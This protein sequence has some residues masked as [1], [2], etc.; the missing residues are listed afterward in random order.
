MKMNRTISKKMKIKRV[1]YIL[2]IFGMDAIKQTI[3]EYLSGGEKRKLNVASEFL[4]D[5]YFIFCDEPTTGLDS[6]NA[7]SVITSLKNLITLQEYKDKL[8]LTEETDN[9]SNKILDIPL[10]SYNN[11]TDDM[12]KYIAKGVVCSIHQPSS[13]IFH[14]FTHIILMNSGRIVYQG[15]VHAATIFF[16]KYVVIMILIINCN[17]NICYFSLRLYCPKNYN[18]A[19]F[20][21]KIIH[22]EDDMLLDDKSNAS[23]IYKEYLSYC[24]NEFN[25]R[26][27]PS[28]ETKKS[29]LIKFIDK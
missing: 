19:E 21:T 17:Y 13:E 24:E 9:N 16:S 4:T 6:F 23:K 5:P 29:K 10:S 8:K 22:T 2:H 12:P 27:E 3:V 26:H 11:E 15:S 7:L 28:V 25:D 14:N 20:Y 1:Y 18:P